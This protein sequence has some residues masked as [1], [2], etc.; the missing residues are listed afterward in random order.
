MPLLNSKLLNCQ[1]VRDA[2]KQPIQRIGVVGAKMASK[3][4]KCCVDN[5]K[6][7]FLGKNPWATRET[8]PPL[9]FTYVFVLIYNDFMLCIY[10]WN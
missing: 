1:K 8:E 4:C 9:I 10:H 3:L 2:N 5:V 6:L 7:K